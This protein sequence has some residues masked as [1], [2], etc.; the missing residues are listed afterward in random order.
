MV[1]GYQQH[2]CNGQIQVE[3][4]YSTAWLFAGRC[5]S[6]LTPCD[7]RYAPT[8]FA[9]YTLHPVMILWWGRHV[10]YV[11]LKS[12]VVFA[13]DSLYTTNNYGKKKR[14]SGSGC[15]EFPVVVVVV[16]LC[17]F[18]CC[19]WLLSIAVT[20]WEPNNASYP[21]QIYNVMNIS[22]FSLWSNF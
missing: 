10:E 6:F 1:S 7:A 12:L 4:S 14:V 19:A 3:R 8:L 20:A 17:M 5:A 15:N 18:Y 22:A 21:L 9:N 16:C 13:T 2:A 11:L